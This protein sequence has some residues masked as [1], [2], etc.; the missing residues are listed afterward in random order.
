M[1]ARTDQFTLERTADRIEILD[2]LARYSRA[3]DRLDYNL[4]REVYHEDAVDNHGKDLTVEEFVFWVRERHK[5]ISVSWHSFGN[6][7][8]D[9]A[10]PDLALV[11]SYAQVVQCYPPEAKDALSQLV[12]D[13]EGN[14]T[15]GKVLLISG[16]S[17]DRFERRNNRWKIQ[18]RTIVYESS[19]VVDMQPEP[20]GGP[21]WV[22]GRRD[23]DD[24]S[25]QELRA[26]GICQ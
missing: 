21:S 24:F 15:S 7:L 23:G 22:R 10:G 19:I 20:K 1:T 9:F 4:I 2:V 13:V 14:T 26:L 18:R 16:R 3:I 12:G 17:V 5:T 6:V 11:E 25:F 8:I